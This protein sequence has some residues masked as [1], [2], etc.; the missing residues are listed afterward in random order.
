MLV[1]LLLLGDDP[2]EVAD[3]YSNLP[4]EFADVLQFGDCREPVGGREN[5]GVKIRRITDGQLRG[6]PQDCDDLAQLLLTLRGVD[7]GGL[8]I[9]ATDGD[10]GLGQPRQFRG[11]PRIDDR[12]AEFQQAR[13]EGFEFA[14]AG[15]RRQLREHFQQTIQEDGTTVG[16]P[17][18]RRLSLGRAIVLR[19]C[20][21]VLSFS[22]RLL[23]SEFSQFCHPSW[24]PR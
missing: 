15:L 20:L 4:A 3:L 5:L 23:E 14:R 12:L 2:P 18:A 7:A 24:C 19:D 11:T 10:A 16:P 13:P 21:R 6:I 17:A 9:R 8:E 1:A 22:G